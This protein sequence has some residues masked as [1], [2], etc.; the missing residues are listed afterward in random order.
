M[1]GAALVSVQRLLGHS[2]PKITERRYGHLLSEFM[3]TEVNRLRFGLDAFA[4]RAPSPRPSPPLRGGEGE[5]L[6]QLAP[7]LV[8]PTDSR[9]TEAGTPGLSPGIPASELAGCRGLEPLASGVTVDA[10]WMAGARSDSQVAGNAGSTLE[11]SSPF[12]QRFGALSRPLGTSLVQTGAADAGSVRWVSVRE[13]A[14]MLRVST[15]TVY[16]AVAAGEIPHV[17]VSN[18]IRIAVPLARE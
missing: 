9:N 17:R 8:Q 13:L 10:S 11:R 6:D 18:A 5:L 3:A 12:L 2:D 1:S 4:P 7:P 16:Q 15:S 14:A